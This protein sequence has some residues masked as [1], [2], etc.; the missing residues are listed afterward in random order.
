MEY[1]EFSFIGFD[2]SPISDPSAS[3]QL[4]ESLYDNLQFPILYHHYIPPA[5]CD[6][7]NIISNLFKALSLR[8]E[9]FPNRR[10]VLIIC[11][12]NLYINKICIQTKAYNNV[13]FTTDCRG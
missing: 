2:D 13:S 7:R 10:Q 11:Y 12:D 9:E 1:V 4:I 6:C 5:G 3:K 8:K